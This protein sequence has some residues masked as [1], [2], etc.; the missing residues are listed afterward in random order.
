MDA[1]YLTAFER[2]TPSYGVSLQ[3]PR[4]SFLET[5]KGDLLFL[6]P[7]AFAVLILHNELQIL[8]MLM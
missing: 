6:N 1:C 5:S 3:V 7:I 4:G 8:K 2:L